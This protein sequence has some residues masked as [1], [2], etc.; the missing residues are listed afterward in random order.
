MTNGD[1]H[2]MEKRYA[3][4]LW[5]I[6]GFGLGA[7]IF[8]INNLPSILRPIAIALTG[9]VSVLIAAVT[10]CCVLY[11]LGRAIFATGG[12]RWWAR[13][14][15]AGDYMFVGFVT[16]SLLFIAFLIGY[17]IGPMIFHHFNL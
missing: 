12:G 6:L 2:E 5:I 1:R 9:A 8:N 4:L 3:A 15:G 10:V 16:A 13:G 11:L 7:V 17:P 14:V